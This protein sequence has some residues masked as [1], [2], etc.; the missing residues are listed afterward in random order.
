MTTD[1]APYFYAAYALVWGALLA[2]AIFIGM[3]VRTLE[4][5]IAK[6][7]PPR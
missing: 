2:Y 5:R 4:D 3:R 1:K 7:D 6:R